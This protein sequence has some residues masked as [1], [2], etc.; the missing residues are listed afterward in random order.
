MPTLFDFYG[1][2][3]GQPDEPP[4]PPKSGLIRR[5]VGDTAVTAVK[6]A[7]SLPEMAVGLG[8][9]ASGGRVG[10]AAEE[11]GFRPKEARAFLDTLYSPEQQ[12]ANREVQQAE[13]FID[14]AAA[15]LRNPSTIFHAVVE[16]A[17]S[18]LPAAGIARA[19]MALKANPLLAI[20]A[21]EGI[22]SAGQTAEQIRQQTDD[23]L[24]T[25]QQSLIA[26]TS[27]ALTG[28]IG[29]V[30]GK[31]ANKLGIGDVQQML[32]GVQQA[33]PRAEKALTRALLEGF[34]T[35]GILQELP[36]SAQEQIAQNVALGKPWDEGV[37]NAA[38][39]GALAG[40]VMGVGGAGLGR[41]RREPEQ[42]A[43]P[44]PVDPIAESSAKA[45]EAMGRLATADNV[46]DMAKAASDFVESTPLSQ[47]ISAE[48]EARVMQSGEELAQAD[49]TD[50]KNMGRLDKTPA[51]GVVQPAPIIPASEEGP[52]P[53]LDRL[54][55]AT[56][57]LQDP[58][59]RQ[60][61][62][63]A[64][65]PQYLAQ[66]DQYAETANTP[67]LMDG[68]GDDVRERFL[69][70]LERAVF[71]DRF[72]QP[73]PEV[74]RAERR[75]TDP[76]PI[77][78]F[79]V[80]PVT[81]PVLDYV[82]A[83][84]AENTMA[85]RAFVKEFEAGRIT[86]RDVV[87]VM[88]GRNADP[89]GS[90]PNPLADLQPAEPAPNLIQQRLQAAARA[91]QA[92]PTG[93]QIETSR[94]RPKGASDERSLERAVPGEGGAADAG[95]QPRASGVVQGELQQPGAPGPAGAPVP[96]A[97]PSV[98]AERTGRG[99][100]DDALSGERVAQLAAVFKRV[101]D[102]KHPGRDNSK[103][104]QT[105]AAE[106]D[107]LIEAKN[108]DAL[109]GRNLG[110]ADMNPASRAVFEAATGVKLPKG[111]AAT[112]AAIDQWAG[113]T[114][115]MRAERKAAK[116]AA[117][118]RKRADDASQFARQAAERIQVNTPDGQFKGG[119]YVDDL[120]AKGFDRIVS[121]GPKTFLANAD[122]NGFPLPH[123]DLSGYA[124]KAV[125]A[126]EKGSAQAQAGT[127]AEGAGGSRPTPGQA[128]QQERLRDARAIGRKASEE[129]KPRTP[130]P[131][132]TTLEKQVWRAGWDEA[133]AT[134]GATPQV[135]T[136]P[137]DQVAILPLD[138]AANEAAT[139][140][141]N[142][143][144]EPTDAQKE[145]GNYKVGRIKVGGLDISIENPAGSERSGV[146][147][148][149][150]AWRNT[151]AHHY[152]YIRRSEGADG[153]HVDV[154]VNPGTPEDYEGTV[155]VVDQADPKTGRFDEHKVMM[156]FPSAKAA[157]DAYQANYAKDWKGL[158][159]VQ[160]MSMEQFKAWVAD[161]ANTR[162]PAAKGGPAGKGEQTAKPDELVE[163][164]KRESVLK[165]LRECL[166]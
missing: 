60:R 83:K 126:R 3:L 102:Q 29:G 15:A 152:G 146:D 166:G 135:P 40:G 41:L 89:L 68:V 124:R 93:I 129:G 127:P 117:L 43:P 92:Q 136:K 71:P 47:G 64:A 149:G 161:P 28:L 95:S 36:Q 96:S 160:P 132:F 91:G 106:L 22:V 13:G 55:I 27:G 111:R 105:I 137:A 100:G 119:A 70:L 131:A 12:A 107:A 8:S 122:G 44:A 113:V 2:D 14:T 49:L 23:G 116:S 62:E 145:A 21:G 88:Q 99:L 63:Q 57:A 24:L 162:K 33:G 163:L 17:P 123:A 9:L 153:D 58:A 82:E 84:R 143:L 78:P 94:A 150:K 5:A 133:K 157:Q 75:K 155:F 59:V 121:R 79:R 53:F 142:D 26:G 11:A 18:M 103:A 125:A 19:G 147:P 87:R 97:V 16:S 1:I 50:I 109:I 138:Q 67:G 165:S 54:L 159:A 85:A 151:L 32:A 130:P 118:D 52:A 101:A 10:K 4:P 38:A 141:Q 31:I 42:P 46:E 86:R 90:N 56:E 158:R 104:A 39:M 45:S 140:P 77:E 112:E 61:V 73:A 128:N 51:R 25:G 20:G 72:R 115:E 74:P 6:A 108:A 69:G 134:K 114:P 81:D 148:D 34:A 120:I 76:V 37:G 154:F 80:A 30:A 164:R 7:I 35:E 48:Q 98:D 110:S 65:G 156:G 144:P 139:S 66:L